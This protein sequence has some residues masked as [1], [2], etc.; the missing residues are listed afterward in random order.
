MSP[1]P[2]ILVAGTIVHAG[3][4]VDALRSTYDIYVSF[5]PSPALL[6]D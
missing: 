6:Q 5:H 1:K 3:A 4:E 2:Q